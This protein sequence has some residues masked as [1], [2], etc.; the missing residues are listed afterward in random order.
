MLKKMIQGAVIAA[1]Y[2]LLTLILAPIGFGLIQCRISEALCILPLFT[3][4]A[5]P[6]LFIGCLLSNLISGEIMDI[7]FGSLATLLAAFLTYLVGRK[8]S[9]KTARWLAPL[10]AVVI[11]ALVVGYLIA[12][13]YGGGEG[14][15]FTVSAL[16]VAAGQALACYGLGVPLSFALERYKNKLF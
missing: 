1:I 6:G 2:A 15:G 10:P 5:V 8:C 16:A 9:Q 7:I 3:P 4:A 12:Y 11:N 13:V 14:V